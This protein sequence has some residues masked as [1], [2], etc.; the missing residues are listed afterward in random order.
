MKTQRMKRFF[1][2]FAVTAIV[3]TCSACSDSGEEGAAP[4]A[5]FG[6][7]CS[8]QGESVCKD[9]F[10]C[11]PTAQFTTGGWCTR[12]CT[13]DADCPSWT[14]KGHCAGDKQSRCEAGVCR[15]LLCK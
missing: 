7:A 14:E 4:P 8:P 12:S 3:V 10:S 5:T 2:S 6:L 13:S 15:P 9:P 11:F 1:R